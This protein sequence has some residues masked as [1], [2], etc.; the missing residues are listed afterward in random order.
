MRSSRVCGGG[1]RVW[2]MS[3]NVMVE[4]LIDK[5]EELPRDT[6]VLEAGVGWEGESID[7]GRWCPL[8]VWRRKKEVRL[9]VVSPGATHPVIEAYWEPL[10]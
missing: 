9:F 1:W 4:E 2:G 8:Q 6:P 5:L 3:E 7:R 10:L